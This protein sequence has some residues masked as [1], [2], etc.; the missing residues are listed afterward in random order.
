MVYQTPQLSDLSLQNEKTYLAFEMI[1]D[2]VQPAI[3]YKLAIDFDKA[4]Y[5]THDDGVYTI[6]PL[7]HISSVALIR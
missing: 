2:E 3:Q 6:R 4:C 5:I 7:L 1:G